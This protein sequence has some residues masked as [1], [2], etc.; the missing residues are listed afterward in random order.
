MEAS[1]ITDEVRALIG[2]SSEPVSVQLSRHHVAKALFAVS[3]SRDNVPQD[4]EIAPVCAFG[5]IEGEGN[6]LDTPTLMPK[7]MIVSNDW[8]F[9]RPMRVGETYTCARRIVDISERLGGRFGYA[10]YI[11]T[12]NEF[13]DAEGN[14]VAYATTN[15]MQYD[16]ANERDRGENE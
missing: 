16:P 7:F 5:S 1:L 9:E 15:V 13:R 6:R 14:L 4:G 2:A 10:I 3:G 11:R 8:S 12:D